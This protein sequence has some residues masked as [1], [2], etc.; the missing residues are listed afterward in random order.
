MKMNTGL[1][2]D[3]RK[4]IIVML[5]DERQETIEPVA[6]KFDAF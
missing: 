4:A 6:E 1:W 5:S 3:H 2:I